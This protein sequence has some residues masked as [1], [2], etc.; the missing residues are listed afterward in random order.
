ML[1]QTYRQARSE[2]L[3]LGKRGSKRVAPRSALRFRIASHC[4]QPWLQ[5]PE[6]LRLGYSWLGELL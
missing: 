6:T 1:P 2:A 5:H 3:L 4:A